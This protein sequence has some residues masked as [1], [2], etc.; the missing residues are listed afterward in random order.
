MKVGLFIP[1]FVNELFPH[2]AMATLEL[3]EGY[4]V[5]VAY[6]MEQSCCGQPLANN[7]DSAGACDAALRFTAVF[8]DFDYV[9]A[10]SGSCV[11]HVT[12]HYPWY[13]A[14]NADFQRLKPR[15]YEIVEFLQ[16]VLKVDRLPKPVHFPHKVSIHQSCHGLRELHHASPSELMIPYQS[17]L[18]RILQLVD[19]IEIGLPERRDECCGFGGTFSVDEA[20]V[21]VAM[22][23]DR[24]AQHEATGAEYIVGADPSCL[25]HMG[26]IIRH[27]GRPIRPLHVVEI[28]TGRGG[29]A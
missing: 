4:G 19:G 25:M 28:L 23:R 15:V 10:P 3:L 9:V 20:E 14:D 18:E 27:N 6:P 24:V 1:C 13:I 22:G 26:G 5:E 21:S 8:K 12:H 2:V 7:G 17:R 29:A 11:A 16:D